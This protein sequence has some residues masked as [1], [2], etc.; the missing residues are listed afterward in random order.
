MNGG[1][2]FFFSSIIHVFIWF[3]VYIIKSGA[4]VQPCLDVAAFLILYTFSHR[5]DCHFTHLVF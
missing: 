1:Y 4:V 3:D 5:C 2:H